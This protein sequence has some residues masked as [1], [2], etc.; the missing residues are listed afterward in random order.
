MSI[1]SRLF[2]FGSFE[3]ELSGTPDAVEGVPDPDF[4]RDPVELGKVLA[5]DLSDTL[6]KIYRAIEREAAR[7]ELDIGTVLLHTKLLEAHGD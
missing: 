5:E 6:S 4:L 1:W 2:G 3:K 7:L